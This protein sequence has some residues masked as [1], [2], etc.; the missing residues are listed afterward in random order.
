M[1]STSYIVVGRAHAQH[2]GDLR[3]G[4]PGL[5]L[6]LPFPG[7]NDVGVVIQVR[8]PVNLRPPPQ[9]IAGAQRPRL[10]PSIP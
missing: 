5:A 2:L 4:S 1:R 6:A 8:P 9:P 7:A 3:R 10:R